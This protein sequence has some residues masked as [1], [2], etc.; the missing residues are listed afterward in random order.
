MIAMS[1]QADVLIPGRTQ[2]VWDVLT[3]LQSYPRWNPFIRSAEGALRTDA[4]WRLE[5][6]LDGRLFFP[7]PVVVVECVAGKHLAWRGGPPGLMTGLH[8]FALTETPEGTLLWQ[9]EA[10]S[11]LIAQAVLPMLRTVLRQRFVELNEALKAE[12]SRRADP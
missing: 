6:T 11:G 7:A 3:D 9:S 12:V 10:F 4:R 2:A 5:L 8:G 1:V